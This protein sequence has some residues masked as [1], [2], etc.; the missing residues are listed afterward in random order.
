MGLAD[1]T[2]EG[3]DRAIAEFDQIGRQA[4]LDK[5]GFGEARTHFLAIGDRRYDSKAIV[6]AA[7]AYSRA[8]QGPLPPSD[9]SGGEATVRPTLERLGFTVINVGNRRNPDWIRDELIL[10][11][12]VYLRHRPQIPGK[13]S[14]EILALS[15]DLNRLSVLLGLSGDE[16]FRNPNGVYMKLMNFRRLDPT[17]TA[18]GAT[19]L[20]AGGRGDE[21]VWREFADDRASLSAAAGLIRRAING[22][23]EATAETAT[24][25]DDDEIAEAMEGRLVTRVHRHRERDRKIVASKKR[26]VLKRLGRLEC[27]A[28]GFDFAKRYGKRGEGFAECH[29]TK[30]LRDL[31]EA[32]KITLNDLAIVCA[33]CHRMIHAAAPWL[34]MEELRAIIAREPSGTTG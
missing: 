3:V 18:S 14:A 9:F 21:E 8:G 15:A 17:Y 29:H 25:D 33:N 12:D 30:P 6:G 24:T 1:I 31:V 13:T 28:C 5:Y 2:R 19:G 34:A 7:H 23:E 22:D 32:T 11:L 26:D 4:F 27:E 16:R 20:A 10:A